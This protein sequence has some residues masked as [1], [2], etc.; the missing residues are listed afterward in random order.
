VDCLE[1]HT[2]PEVEIDRA[3]KSRKGFRASVDGEIVAFNAPLKIACRKDAFR[4]LVPEGAP[5]G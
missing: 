2:A 3:H 5:R 4:L 1:L